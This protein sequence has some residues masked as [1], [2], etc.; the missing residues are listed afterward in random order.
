MPFFFLISEFSLLKLAN[1]LAQEKSILSEAPRNFW[2]IGKNGVDLFT[3]L[4]GG[5]SGEIG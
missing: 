5:G 4:N 1:L 2:I 3:V